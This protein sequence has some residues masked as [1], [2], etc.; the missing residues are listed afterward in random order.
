VYGKAEILGKEDPSLMLFKIF[1]EFKREYLRFSL[2]RDL[3]SGI[4][5]FLVKNFSEGYQR[6][7][8]GVF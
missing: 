5:L 3:D 1:Y 4:E 2:T 7:A 6:V 8:C